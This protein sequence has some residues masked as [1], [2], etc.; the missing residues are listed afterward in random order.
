M[1]L[2]LLDLAL[3]QCHRKIVH[4]ISRNKAEETFIPLFGIKWNKANV[5]AFLQTF[6]RKI[7]LFVGRRPY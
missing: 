4:I 1:K 6:N 2:L 3:F 5:Q 7:P